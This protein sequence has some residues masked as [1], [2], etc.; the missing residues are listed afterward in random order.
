MIFD[1]PDEIAE[2]IPTS[3]SADFSAEFIVGSLSTYPRLS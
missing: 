3:F 2:M 1:E